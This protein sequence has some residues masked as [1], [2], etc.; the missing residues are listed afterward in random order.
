MMDEAS[1]PHALPLPVVDER[2]IGAMSLSRAQASTSIA[3]GVQVDC[4]WRSLP[5][6]AVET[7]LGDKFVRAAA[8]G[9]EAIRA[10]RRLGSAIEVRGG[11]GDGLMGC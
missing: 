8:T 10:R 1:G 7:A 6:D 4:G 3:G 5:V 2:C 11:L 9:C